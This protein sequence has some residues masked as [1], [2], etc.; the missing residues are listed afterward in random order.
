VVNS[1]KK[2]REVF[3]V[4]R[5]FPS[6][7]LLIF[8]G[9]IIVACIIAV[10]TIIILSKLGENTTSDNTTS[11][12]SVP[13]RTEENV[14]DDAART[15]L[16]NGDPESAIATYQKSI[17]SYS[18]KE[19]KAKAYIEMASMLYQFY[20]S[21]YKN[22]ILADAYEAEEVFPTAYTATFIYDIETKYGNTVAAD[23]YQALI[24]E[25]TKNDNQEGG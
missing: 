1:D 12:S 7:K 20:A 18:S 19:D 17:E 3:I 15:Y 13:V 11:S 23:K 21:E 24:I 25:R 9:L 10:V 4:H 14:R 5:L 8:A 6:K 2:R 22:Q 16:I